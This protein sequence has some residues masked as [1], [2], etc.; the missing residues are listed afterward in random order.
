MHALH[1]QVAGPE[2]EPHLAGDPLLRGA[3]QRF[4]VAAHRV[5]L[6]ALVDEVAVVGRDLVLDALLQAGE[7]ELFQFP[8]RDQQY[9]GRGR[10]EGHPALGAEHGVAHVDAAADAVGAGEGFQR[11][12]ERHRVHGLAVERS[13]H[14]LGEAPACGA[15]PARLRSKALADSTQALSGID[16]RESS[17]SRPPMV[18]PHRPRLME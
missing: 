15:W 11:L 6:L 13:R 1:E 3:Q 5:E 4:D 17:V 8:V 2:H 9:L 18:T 14:A 16:S 12:D 10:L 7:R